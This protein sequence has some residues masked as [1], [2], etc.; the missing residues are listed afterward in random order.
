MEQY[1]DIE[2]KLSIHR[3]RIIKEYIRQGV[4]PDNQLIQ[5]RLSRID[6][7]LSFAKRLS[8]DTSG[9]FQVEQYNQLIEDAYADLTLLYELLE[10]VVIDRFEQTKKIAEMSIRSYKK[11]LD[12]HKQKND[13][14][15]ESSSFGTVV[16]YK[17]HKFL[18]MND[19]GAISC[20]LGEIN[21]K[22]SSVLSFYIYGKN[23]D[24]SSTSFHL[25]GEDID[26]SCAPFSLA[27]DRIQLPNKTKENRIPLRISKTK[28]D[29][30]ILLPHVPED[31]HTYS[32]L[33][34]KNRFSTSNGSIDM[35]MNRVIVITGKETIRFFVDGATYINFRYVKNEPTYVNFP[36]KY[37]VK[38]I[39]PVTEIELTLENGGF[40]LFTDGAIYASHE[41]CE[42]TKDG[43][44]IDAKYMEEDVVLI[45]GFPPKE[46]T[47]TCKLMLTQKEYPE[48][49]YV[50]IKER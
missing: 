33:S 37:S 12:E 8:M 3:E 29:S 42:Q 40:E 26:E 19:D 39:K 30:A 7:R 47:L 6:A 49:E 43:L 48:I 44:T 11:Q 18:M 35:P 34:G 27:Q 9:L 36:D 22:E 21:V 50:A 10:E 32:A 5:D 24:L 38:N 20:D 23:I 15:T 31:G 17:D 2:R 25:T 28:H 1:L 16:F 13:I 4:F 45:D 46:I 14:M 41:R